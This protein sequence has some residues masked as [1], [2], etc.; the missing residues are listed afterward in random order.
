MLQELYIKNFAIIDQAKIEFR[1]GLN[2]LTGETGAGKSLLVGALELILGQRAKADW[3]RS[4]TDEALVEAIFEPNGRTEMQEALQEAGFP[5]ED[6][7]LVKRMVNR[8]G[9][10]RIYIND[11]AATLGFLDRLGRQLVDIHGQHEHQSLLHVKNHR[12]G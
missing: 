4:D 11:R 1:S 8:S 10:N 6:A 12:S 9:K 5:A 7:L 3:I 2:V